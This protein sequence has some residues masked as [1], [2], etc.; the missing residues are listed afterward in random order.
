VKGLL[1]VP[2]FG[3]LLAAYALNEVAYSF[4]SLALTVLVYRHTHSAL[5][6]AG[7]F[8]CAQFVPAFI[9]PLLVARIEGRSAAL[10]LPILYAVEALLYALLWLLA[11]RF[12][13]AGVL[14]V[15]LLDGTLAVAARSVARAA[16]VAV[17]TP[18]DRLQEGN[19]LINGAFTVSFMVAP[20]VAGAAV[21][22]AGIRV[23]LLVTAG[24]FALVALSLLGM[25]GLPRALSAAERARGRLRQAIAY[26]R[27]T[28]AV[29]RPLVLQG[30]G[31]VAFSISVPV[32]IVFV[33]RSLHGGGAAYGALISTWG[34][35][36]VVGGLIYG[37]W[38]RGELRA[39]IAASAG[40]L[41]VGFLV[42]ALAP[43]L[44]VA[45]AGAAIAGVGNGIEMVAARTLLQQRVNPDWMALVMALNE[46]IFQAA[47][48]G[49]IVIG[50]AVAAL[51]GP[52]VALGT[53][54]AGSAAMAIS[55]W[56]ILAPAPEVAEATES[57]AAEPAAPVS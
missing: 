32:E 8:L 54:A 39:L 41:G 56:L 44:G 33:Q 30:L 20:A 36:A 21:A 22:S 40:A 23:T 14:A 48:G 18:V 5:A 25:R 46:S 12:T 13:L 6:A 45:L 2:A 24:L 11:G 17:L 4:G 43:N 57:E 55:A 29:R 27:G 3:R 28:P 1:R 9:S 26:V 37:R 16:S 47:P 42:M 35:G 51:A 52:R 19:A 34:A 15:T 31:M 38:R 53:A 49:G 7:Y 50:G 10:S